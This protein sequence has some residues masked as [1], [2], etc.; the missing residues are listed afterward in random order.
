MIG[1]AHQRNA[2][3]CDDMILLLNGHMV[4][5]VVQLTK[6]ALLLLLWLSEAAGALV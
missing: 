5:Q 6:A 3:A 1:S 4:M 2:I